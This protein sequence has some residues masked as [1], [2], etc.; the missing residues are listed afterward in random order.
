MSSLAPDRH[1]APAAAK[2][3]WA[4]DRVVVRVA[5]VLAAVMLLAQ[6]IGLVFFLGGRD[7]LFRGGSGGAIEGRLHE[8]AAAILAT[9]AAERDG[10]AAQLS[11]EGIAFQAWPAFRP[12]AP[13]VELPGFRLLRDRLLRDR[14]ASIDQVL[15]EAPIAPEDLGPPLPWSRP[16]PDLPVTA[17]LRLRDGTW[18]AA[19]MRAG[20]LSGEHPPFFGVLPWLGAALSVLLV[21]WLVARRVTASLRRYAAAAERFG[22]DLGAAPLPEAGP[23]EVRAVI[24]AFNRMQSRLK[25]FVA[26]RTRMLAAMSHDL[27]SPIS[28][29]RLRGESL[30]PGEGRNRVLADLALMERMVG[31]TLDFARDDV[32]AE[33]RQRLDLASLVQSICQECE[34]TAGGR[35]VSY[36]GTGYLEVVAAPLALSRA[37]RNVVENALKHGGGAEVALAAL[38]GEARI[39]IADCGPGIP[40]EL[41]ERVFEPFYRLD[42]ARSPDI[43]GSGLGLAIARNALRAHGGEIVLANRAG[44]GLS[45]VVSLPC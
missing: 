30:P 3:G 2:P 36:R 18:L 17:W 25:R 13:V 11:G 23:V 38:P 44:G 34:E 37:I 28:R 1:P 27:M 16:D 43:E 40:P 21:S 7:L 12:Q 15:I 20:A 31:A 10:L 4:P 6:V 41:L 42:A 14:A 29:L 45:A 33:P 39:E 22:R 8:T 19:G 32:A 5:L 35:K 24:Q 9:G 26:D